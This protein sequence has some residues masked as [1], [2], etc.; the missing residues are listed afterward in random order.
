MIAALIVY[1]AIVHDLRSAPPV[2]MTQ[3]RNAEL[4]AARVA[5]KANRKAY[6]A[7]RKAAGSAK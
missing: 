6:H 7:A 2:P 1:G 3:E 5:K 4:I